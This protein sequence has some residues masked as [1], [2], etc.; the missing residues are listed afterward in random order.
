[1][2]LAVNMH[3]GKRFSHESFF[4]LF[5]A[6]TLGS[7]LTWCLESHS[8]DAGE[9]GKAT[10]HD[11]GGPV[12][13]PDRISASPHDRASEPP[14]PTTNDQSRRLRRLVEGSLSRSWSRC[15]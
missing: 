1:M 13:N 15:L 11:T 8:N 9:H 7:P 2:H 5:L 4:Y 10:F 6:I 12:V 3:A 14:P